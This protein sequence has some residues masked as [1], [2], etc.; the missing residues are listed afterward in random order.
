MTAKSQTKRRPN[1]P[2]LTEP[3]KIAEFWKNRRGESVRVSLSTFEGHN[4]VDVRQFFTDGAGQMQA[5]RKG[6]AMSVYRLPE[7]A[8]AI[9]KAIAKARE[10]GLID[11][12]PSKA[13]QRV[14]G[15]RAY[16]EWSGRRT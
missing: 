6:I 14:E 15:E 11:P 1:T 3:V 10:L 4:L 5:T 2:T 12:E 8:A 7:L 13:Q 16:A 9:G